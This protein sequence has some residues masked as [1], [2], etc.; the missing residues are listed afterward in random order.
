M[1]RTMYGTHENTGLVLIKNL[2]KAMHT[3]RLLN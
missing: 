1:H 2:P 3:V